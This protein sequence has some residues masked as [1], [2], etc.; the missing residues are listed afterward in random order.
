MLDPIPVHVDFWAVSVP[1]QELLAHDELEVMFGAQNPFNFFE[2]Y[3]QVSNR[4]FI[5]SE[6]G[7]DAHD[8][9]ADPSENIGRNQDDMDKLG[10][11]QHEIIMGAPKDAMQ[12]EWLLALVEDLEKYSTT[13]VGAQCKVPAASGGWPM[14]WADDVEGTRDRRDGARLAQRLMDQVCPDKNQFFHTPCGYRRG[15]ARPL[16]E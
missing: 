11:D 14:A 5:V 2:T 8:A 12:A 16:R 9:D 10:H 3:A 13:C 1:R 6:F 15:A 7:I 4:P